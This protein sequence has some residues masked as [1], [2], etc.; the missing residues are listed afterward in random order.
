M[1]INNILS[2]NIQKDDGYNKLT[3]IFL[4]NDNDI[5]KLSGYL[6]KVNLDIDVNAGFNPGVGFVT[7]FI[8]KDKEFFTIEDV[9][10]KIINFLE[11]EGD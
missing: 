5:Y 4:N 11:K 3:I 6:K 7:N 9:T 2:F 8:E 10:D 1:T